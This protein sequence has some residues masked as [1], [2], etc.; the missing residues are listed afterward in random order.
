MN[1]LSKK[2]IVSILTI[3]FGFIALMFNQI[4]GETFGL[5]ST[6]NIGAYSAANVGALWATAQ[7]Q[8]YANS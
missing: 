6:V 8:R 5:I 3:T 4:T 7:E 2:F 1:L